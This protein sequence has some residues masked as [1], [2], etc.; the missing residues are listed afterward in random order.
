MKVI[1]RIA[2]VISTL[3][4]C[5]NVVHAS[6]VKNGFEALKVKD[7]FKAK[8]LLSKGMKYNPEASSYGL[9]IIYSRSDNP[10]YDKDSA[11]RYIVIA[12]TSWANAKEKKKEKWKVYDWTRPSIDSMLQL[13]SGQFYSASKQ[14]HT[15]ECY[16]E[17]LFAHPWS[18]RYNEVLE[19]R[20]SLAFFLAMQENTAEAYMDFLSAYP[21][22]SYAPMAEDNYHNSDFFEKTK[23]GSIDSYLKF[24]EE[25]PDSPMR[26][27]AER[28]VY[29][30]VTEPNTLLAYELFVLGYESNSNNKRAW[31]EY[32]QL[33]ISDYS[34]KR[35]QTFLDKYPTA[36]N[37]EE[38]EKDLIWYDYVLLRNSIN[39]EYDGR[40]FG[41]I[42]VDGE[43]I[44]DAKY[45]FVGP[46]SSGLAI[47]VNEE[48]YGF[49][50]KLGRLRIPC[51]YESV[52]EFHEGR[53]VVEKGGK[54]G[55]ID[56]NNKLLLPFIYEDLGDVSNGLIYVSKGD[57]YGYA[58]ENGVLVIPEKFNEVFGFSE[59]I[60]KVEENGKYGM[61]NVDGEYV[62]N[63]IYEELT[64][65][66]D[67]LVLCVYKGKKGLLTKSGTVVISPKYN[68]IGAFHDGLAL[69][70]KTDTIE[71]I[72]INGE[73][74][75]SKGYKTYPNFLLK[76]VFNQGTAIV[77]KKDRYGKINPY[78]NV[79]TDIKYDNIGVGKTFT[80]F[81]KEGMWGLMSSSNKLLIS[82]Q[83]ESMDLVDEKYVITRQEDSV[84]VLDVMGNI[85]IPLEF[86]GVEY[87]KNGAF[88]VSKDNLLGLYIE[89]VLCSEVKYETIG[90]FNDDFVHLIANDEYVYY[91]LVR[92][93]LVVS[94]KTGE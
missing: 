53:S 17:F 2:I 79:V 66:T 34:K 55:M 1:S 58:N 21:E 49:I 45:D 57:K 77:Y 88:I 63:A 62:I 19:T 37:K 80:P 27:D 75:I 3:F 89:G 41:F 56:R 25:Y 11:Y 65:L 10:F 28:T 26:P 61:I 87:L 54:Y 13:I 32:Y 64:P 39:F 91:D 16:T 33:Y 43:Q 68:E 44:I 30:L 86:D 47:V 92:S 12:D 93:K 73:V 82:A 42:N 36:P 8:K 85:M 78:G 69:V 22:S 14:V 7:Y 59:G 38:I 31:E 70:S 24:I 72:N 83:Y 6:R 71:Y 4:I 81:E 90:L 48:K 52:T 5:C 35:I 40:K 51:E 20:D 50:D 15:V 84:G 94:K 18:N 9:S 67:S 76:G 74:V 29:E 60:A 23:D 46:F